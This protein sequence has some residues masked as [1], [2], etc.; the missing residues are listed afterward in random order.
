MWS[1][2]NP[3]VDALKFK[4]LSVI[5]VKKYL[6]EQRKKLE[7]RIRYADSRCRNAA[8]A[9]LTLATGS[10]QASLYEDAGSTASIDV[11]VKHEGAYDRSD[12]F[13]LKGNNGQQPSRD[14]HTIFDGA[15]NQ[16][17]ITMSCSRSDLEWM[18][19]QIR[20]FNEL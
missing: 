11:F 6:W 14:L 15:V 16:F 13:W 17:T 12:V 5:K 7:G 4:Q 1:L 2:C 18:L 19:A 8:G 9:V 10:E 20:G 3:I